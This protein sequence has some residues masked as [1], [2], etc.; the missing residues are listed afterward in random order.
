MNFI[1]K[2]LHTLVYS[3]LFIA[4][5]AVLMTRQTELLWLPGSLPDQTF[6]AFVFFATLCTYSFHYYFT[7]PSS[8][9]TK[10]NEWSLQNR[11]LLLLLFL[12]G[13][14]GTI[15]FSIPLLPHWRY[16]IPAA[17][18]TFL[19]TAPQLP[20]PFFRRLRK[21]AY[22]KTI[23]LALIWTYATSILPLLLNHDRWESGFTI[24]ATGRYFLIYC[25]CILF[26]YRDRETDRQ[27]GVKSLITYLSDT[28]IH[29]LF[30]FSLLA[31]LAM[32]IL[33]TETGQNERDIILLLLP[34]I[35]LLFLY[36]PA[37]KK[38]TDILFLVI[39]DGLMALSALLLL[40][41]RI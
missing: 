22:G 35:L 29:R 37:K 16:I 18:A 13:L 38:P 17:I 31:C 9:H 25:I 39:L 26:D 14:A 3:N 30:V 20:H 10:R 2:L 40:L 28:G 8:Q 27:N 1:R 23:F 5:C 36:Q 41:A 32:T 34:A 11:P 4:A 15:Y 33:L 21:Y 12:S 6:L 7:P 24:Y 19:Y